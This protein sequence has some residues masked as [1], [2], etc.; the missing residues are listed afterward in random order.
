[1]KT[2]LSCC[3]AFAAALLVSVASPARA[4]DKNT[5]KLRRA[6]K[7]NIEIEVTSKRAFPA[8]GAIPVVHIGAARSNLS[9]YLASGSLN[10]LIFTMSA[11]EFAR[12]K[13]GDPIV[14]KYD[15]DSQGTWNFGKLDRSKLGK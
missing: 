13:N 1:M 11:A 5:V 2:T 3:V 12:A 4:S 6:A 10:T 7:G 14:V 15:P 9:R 8:V